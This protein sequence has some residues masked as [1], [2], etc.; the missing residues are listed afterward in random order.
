MALTY[1]TSL[2]KMKQTAG[3]GG[4]FMKNRHY[5][6]DL[7]AGSQSFASG[8]VVRARGDKLVYVHHHLN[9][10]ACVSGMWPGCRRDVWATEVKFEDRGDGLGDVY[11]TPRFLAEEGGRP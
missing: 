3:D 10:T 4:G 7:F 11:I 9:H 1:S 2:N 6:S 8:Q 5:Q